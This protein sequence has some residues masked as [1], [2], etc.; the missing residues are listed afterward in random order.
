MSL[1]LP[2]ANSPLR[3]L[4]SVAELARQAAPENR[5]KLPTYR[6]AIVG[7]RMFLTR[8]AARSLN[9]LC[10]TADGHLRLVR[11]GIRGGVKRL[12]D[13]GAL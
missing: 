1:L 10:V 7:A 6:D 3:S 13:F 5:G 2:P 11:V 4:F 12:W 8:N 9:T